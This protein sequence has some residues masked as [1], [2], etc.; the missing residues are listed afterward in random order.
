MSSL[1]RLT[2]SS[3]FT[4]IIPRTAVKIPIRNAWTRLK[5]LGT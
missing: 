5:G 1:I 2:A 4:K 3:I